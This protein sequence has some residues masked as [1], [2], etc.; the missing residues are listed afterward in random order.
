MTYG[1]QIKK[2]FQIAIHHFRNSEFV[3]YIVYSIKDNY[4]IN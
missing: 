1:K 3:M 4:F 2:N